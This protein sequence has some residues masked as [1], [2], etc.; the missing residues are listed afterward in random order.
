MCE[1]RHVGMI[2]NRG[3]QCFSTGCDVRVQ[4]KFGQA[5]VPA[6]GVSDATGEVPWRGQE[7]ERMFP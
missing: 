1:R 6:S 2:G 5:P 7:R 3:R 4:Q